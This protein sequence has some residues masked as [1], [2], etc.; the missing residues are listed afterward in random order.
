MVNEVDR[1]V[2]H[3]RPG[4]FIPSKNHQLKESGVL[5][6]AESLAV[7]LRVCQLGEQ[8]IGGVGQ[9]IAPRTTGVLLDT[10][11]RRTVEWQLT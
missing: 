10:E 11:R 3:S 6:L 7:D 1:K 2:G 4:C 5:G 9:T 8:V